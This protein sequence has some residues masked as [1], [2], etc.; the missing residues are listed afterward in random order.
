MMKTLMRLPESIA[1]WFAHINFLGPLAIRLYL[2]PIFWMAGTE[3]LAHMEDTIQWFGNTQWGLGLPFPTLMAYLATF[4]EIIGAVCLLF[5]FATRWIAIPLIITMIMAMVTVHMENGWLAIASQSSEAHIRLQGFLDW[6]QQTYPQRHHYLTELGQPVVLN[7]GIEFAMTY[8]IMLV[9][10]F[11]TGAG[12]F[13]SVDYWL[14]LWCKRIN[15][16]CA[17]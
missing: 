16:S 8:L 14:L 13:L 6:L 11:F 3:K 17:N 5:G 9:S 12:R 15:K 1:G 10:L 2:V 4:S 7:N